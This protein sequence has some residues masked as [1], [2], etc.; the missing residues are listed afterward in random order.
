MAYFINYPS[1]SFLRYTAS[2]Y[3]YDIELL[4]IV[5]IAIKQSITSNYLIEN[6]TS[7]PNIRRAIM[8]IGSQEKLWSAVAM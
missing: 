4:Y 6:A 8:N 1:Y 5:M 7:R 2:F 3:H